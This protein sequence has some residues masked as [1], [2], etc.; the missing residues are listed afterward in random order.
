MTLTC[1]S[2][3]RVHSGR[4]PNRR[5]ASDSGPNLWLPSTP[6]RHGNAP[7]NLESMERL[8][9]IPLPRRR[10]RCGLELAGELD[11]SESRSVATRPPVRGCRPPCAG[12][13][14]PSAPAVSPPEPR[15][16]R[17][18]AHRLQLLALVARSAARHRCVVH[19]A[20]LSARLA[21]PATSVLTNWPTRSAWPCRC[22]PVSPHAHG[23][24]LDDSP[25]TFAAASHAGGNDVSAPLFVIASSLPRAR[26]SESTL[27]DAGSLA[28]ANGPP[29]SCS[30]V[31]SPLGHRA[32]RGASASKTASA[33]S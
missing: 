6:Y 5:R 14:S 2:G 8:E 12:E 29:R 11:V 18:R 21:R 31:D 19:A 10:R 4:R 33:C 15:T 32:R 23:A 22:T 24:A 17:P 30:A 26:S 16:S 7:D 13:P 27:L 20:A 9:L 28:L 25:G 3:H 1:S